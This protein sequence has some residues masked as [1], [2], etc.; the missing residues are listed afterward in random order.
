[1]KTFRM[2]RTV[3]ISATHDINQVNPLDEIQFE[4]AVFSDGKVVIRWLTKKRSVAVWDSMEDMLA[5]HGHPEYGSKLI[6]DGET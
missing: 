6:W 5:I 4:G 3:D 2:Y 1:M